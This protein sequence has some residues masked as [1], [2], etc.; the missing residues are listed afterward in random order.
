LPISIR[1]KACVEEV[2]KDVG[3]VEVLVNNAGITRDMTFKKMGKADWDAVIQHQPRLSLQHD[4]AGDGRHD[5]AQAGVGS[6][7]SPR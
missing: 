7:T 3:P 6:S 5:G 2:V 1:A 4:Q